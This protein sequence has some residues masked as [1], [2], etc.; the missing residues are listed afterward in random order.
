VLRNEP[1]C[2][3]LGYCFEALTQDSGRVVATFTNGETATSDV[4]I[5]CDGSVSKVR[6]R[7]FGDEVVNYTGQV[8]FRALLPMT[9]VPADQKNILLQCSS[10][11]IDSCFNT[12]YAI[13]Q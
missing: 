4:L 13:Q 8:A 7:L 5:G 1:D 2:V 3:F 6:A 11:L 9:D 10:V 12:H